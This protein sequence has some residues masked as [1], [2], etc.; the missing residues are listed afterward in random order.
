MSELKTVRLYGELAEKFGKEFH[1]AVKTPAQA[2]RLLGANFK[3]FYPHLV[4]KSEPG[5]HIFIDSQSISSDQLNS[6]VSSKEVIRIVPV[7]EGGDMEDS[8]TRVVVGMALVVIGVVAEVPT[9][10]NAGYLL[11]MDGVAQ[12]LAGTP[13]QISAGEYES[14]ENKPSYA[15]DGPV[16]TTRQGNAVALG[17]GRVRIGSQVLSAGMFAESI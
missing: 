6:P 5:Y 15:F 8:S 9:I 12:A 14:P 16:N 17:Y 10:A 1:F 3:D 7:V 2:I 13:S 4:S 11:M